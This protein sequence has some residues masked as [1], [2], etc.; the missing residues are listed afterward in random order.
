MSL[1]LS[2]LTRNL[3]MTESKTVKRLILADDLRGFR[4]LQPPIH[5]SK[6]IEDKIADSVLH[7]CAQF[8]SLEILRY[9][10]ENQ[11][12][13]CNQ[14]NAD[15][16][17][18]LHE[19]VLNGNFDVVKLLVANGAKIDALKKADW[20]PLMLAATKDNL[21]IIRFLVE[22]NADVSLRNKDGWT[23]FHVG[24]FCRVC[25]RKKALWNIHQC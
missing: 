3:D 5:P 13:N 23:A 8:N 1:R 24:M 18:P 17:T 6:I 12:C 7:L 2:V 16:K 9:L 22:Q 25:F 4:A 14:E 15:Y 10:L 11:D 20:T 19:A 21:E